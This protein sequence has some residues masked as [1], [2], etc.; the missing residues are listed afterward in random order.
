MVKRADGT[1]RLPE[2][3]FELGGVLVGRAEAFIDS[4]PESVEKLRSIFTLKL[5]AVREDGEPTRRQARRSEFSDEEWRLV[6][7]LADHPYRLL[8]TATL[9]GSDDPEA[10]DGQSPQKETHAEVAH[11]AIFRRWT[12]LREWIAGEREFLVW[13]NRLETTR[14][15]WVATPE[16]LRPGA[17]LMGLSLAQARKWLAQRGDDIAPADRDFI[18]LSRKTEERQHLKIRLSLAAL[19]AVILVGIAGWM[20]ERTIMDTWRWMMVVRPY[21]QS[22]IRPNV[23][24]AD[25]ESAL[26]PGDTFRECARDCPRM[27]VVP[28]GTFVM[29]SPLEEAGHNR[30]ETPQ[31][32]VTIAGSLAVSRFE[33]TFADWDACATY[34]D[35]RT[36]VRDN[37]WGRGKQ[38]VIDVTWDD[39]KRYVAWLTRMTGREYR[40]LSEAEWSTRRGPARQTAYAWGDDVGAARA[41]CKGCG[42]QWDAVRTAP[43]GSFAPNAFGLYDMHG[44]VW[45]WV[46]DCYHATYDGA[47]NDGTAWHDAGECDRPV[48]RGGSLNT[49]PR[50]IRSALRGR[51]P[52]GGK[53]SDIGFR[54]ARTLATV[55]A[56][57]AR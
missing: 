38:P 51:G 32:Q 54:V 47:P 2:Q 11:E 48:I 56:G 26:K 9:N 33:V 18:M 5:A 20:N 17:L 44:N 53:A 19:A 46:E 10:I 55:A 27:V 4:H 42:S 22:E 31:H 41:N 14:R 23:L 16:P 36:T 3:A 25:A 39:A 8:I 34:G 35:C 30:D 1:L 37:D 43:A 12:R 45:E 40:L 29:G 50:Y 52:T 6:S 15:A 24:T 57:D 13:R 21:M 28:A 7:D 49:T